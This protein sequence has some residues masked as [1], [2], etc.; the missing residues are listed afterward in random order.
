[1]QDTSA[2]KQSQ[3]L[4]WR[5]RAFDADTVDTGHL[6]LTTA[7]VGSPGIGSKTGICVQDFSPLGVLVNSPLGNKQPQTWQ[8]ETTVLTSFAVSLGFGWHCVLDIASCFG[9]E[10]SRF[11]EMSTAKPRAKSCWVVGIFNS[12][13]ALWEDCCV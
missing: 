10:P 12:V 1:V 7:W 9:L 6:T 3:P 4:T 13:A 11:P 8:L 2:L 5:S